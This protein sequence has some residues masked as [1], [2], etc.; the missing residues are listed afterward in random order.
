M[1]LYS[2]LK[3]ELGRRGITFVEEYGA[4]QMTMC[5]GTMKWRCLLTASGDDIICCA[6]FPW[7]A[8]TGTAKKL[9]DLNLTL[10]TGC[11]MVDKGYVILRC[12]M[13]INDPM[14]CGEI[15]A[16]LLRRCGKEVCRCW[17][18][19]YLAVEVTDEL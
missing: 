19:V 17:N 18:S 4:F 14:E 7:R 6:Q 1:K 5:S 9:N 15:A 2:I 3:S 13:E 11:F 16:M 10:N 12:G 8:G